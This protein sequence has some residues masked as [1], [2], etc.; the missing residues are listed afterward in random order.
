[1]ETLMTLSFLVPLALGPVEFRLDG[2]RADAFML[3]VVSTSTVLNLAGT[4]LFLK[5]GAG[6]IHGALLKVSGL[7]EVYGI[8]VDPMSVLIGVVVVTAGLVFMVYSMDYIGPGNRGHPIG[9]G[10][11]RFYAWMMLSMGATLAFVYSSTI[12]QLLIFFEL[13]SLA[14][15]GII[16]YYRTEKSRRAARKA[17]TTTNFGAMAGLY[18]ATAIAIIKLH[19]LSLYSLGSLSAHLR[20]L[21][22]IAIMIAAFA[23]SAQF[24]FY[25]WLPDAMEAPAPASAF[26]HGAVMV[27]MGVFLLA[28]FLQFMG[29]VPKT[30]FYVMAFVVIATQIVSMAMY[31]AQKDAKR[32]LAYAMMGES[33]A[34]YTALAATLLGVGTGVKAA[35]FQIFNHAYA[36]GLAFMM[37]GA[38]SY[39]LGTRDM[40]GI[41][42][43]IRLPILGYGW[44]MAM[45]GLAGIPPF[46]VFFGKM[47]ILSTS[48][49]IEG[50]VLM[51]VML[52][53]MLMNSVVLLM[54]S[55][56]RFHGMVFSQGDP[57]GNNLTGSMKA[58]I[59]TMAA[60]AVL[61]PLIA[62]PLMMCGGW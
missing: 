37:V 20:L 54:V 46:G 57:G 13:M 23:K 43:L 50:S 2:R 59:L 55:L 22:I 41:K 31:P 60:L 4:L 11:G 25:S 3:F 53:L 58:C 52:F 26:L 35:V 8:I 40:N 45:L 16:S 14:C 1:M 51:A 7:G 47:A 24:P 61:A 15:W 34:M 56:R 49:A 18:T 12:L 30:A 27:E 9:E 6:S 62:Y 48:K 28:R 32:L 38:F 21:M 39:V 19:N 36:G 5:G 44:G 17:L 29:P 42:G 33:S 10:K